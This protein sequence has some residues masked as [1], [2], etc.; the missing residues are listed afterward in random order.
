[1]QRLNVTP[2]ASIQMQTQISNLMVIQNLQE[3]LK[4]LILTTSVEP[5]TNPPVCFGLCS[6]EQPMQQHHEAAAVM[7][8]E[9]H[10]S[11]EP[12]EDSADLSAD[13]E[14]E[15]KRKKSQKLF[16]LMQKKLKAPAEQIKGCQNKTPLLC[17]E[18]ICMMANSKKVSK[19]R[20]IVCGHP[21]RE[22]YAKG[23]CGSCYLR[24]G[25]TKKPWNCPHDKLYALGLCQKCYANKYNKV[26]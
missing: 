18:K 20:K 26:K 4:Y 25:R 7:E 16:S 24:H 3:Y 1:M 2:S 6:A 8:E 5:T 11:E 23:L 12:E 19:D 14:A 15:I 9:K 21:D 10:T 17:H 22:H 13:E